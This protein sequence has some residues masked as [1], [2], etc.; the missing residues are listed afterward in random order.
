MFWLLGGPLRSV[1]VDILPPSETLTNSEYLSEGPTEDG[2][3]SPPAYPWTNPKWDSN[4][5]KRSLDE[6]STLAFGHYIDAPV[7]IPMEKAVMPWSA[8]VQESTPTLNGEMAPTMKNMRFVSTIV[9]SFAVL[10]LA[11]LSLQVASWTAPTADKDQSNARREPRDA[12]VDRPSSWSTIAKLHG[13]TLFGA[14]TYLMLNGL[15]HMLLTLRKVH[16]AQAMRNDKPNFRMAFVLF[17]VTTICAM[18]VPPPNS[19]EADTFLMGFPVSAF[20]LFI[21]SLGE[22]FF[23]DRDLARRLSN[24]SL[25]DMP[26]PPDSVNSAL[27]KGAEEAQPMAAAGGNWNGHLN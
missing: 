9:S 24:L 27:D 26:P 14:G 22:S 11:V 1:S 3:E 13:Y 18:L 2:V 5:A 20:A 10:L 4:V 19:V 23:Y 15:V 16:Q 7:P 25:E 6:G 8:P 21:V 12:L 17:L